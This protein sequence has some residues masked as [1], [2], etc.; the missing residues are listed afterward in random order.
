MK[1]SSENIPVLLVGGG[2]F[3]VSDTLTGASRVV[4]ATWSGVAN[5]V[6][7][8][9]ARVSGIVDSIEDTETR[10]KGEIVQEQS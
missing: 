6:G 3:V 4:K 1:T 9:A 8:A 5:A 10:L 7:A 2:A